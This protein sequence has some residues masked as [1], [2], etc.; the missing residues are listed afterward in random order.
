M[1]NRFAKAIQF[2][3]KLFIG[4]AANGSFFFFHSFWKD[5]RRIR[6]APDPAADEW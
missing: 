3:S 2:S 6:N 5:A 1:W 4:F